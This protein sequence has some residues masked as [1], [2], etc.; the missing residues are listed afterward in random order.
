MPCSIVDGGDLATVLG[1]AQFGEEEGGRG[2]SDGASETD[3]KT[4]TNEHAKALRSGLKGNT[5]HHKEDTGNDGPTTTEVIGDVR[6]EG[7]TANGPNTHN[8]IEE[9]QN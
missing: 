5:E 4:G 2:L 9:A 8:G 1:V 3:E 7:K 6:R